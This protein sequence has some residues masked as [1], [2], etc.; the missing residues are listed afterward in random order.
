[1]SVATRW[2][3]VRVFVWHE[4]VGERKLPV[5]VRADAEMGNRRRVIPTLERPSCFVPRSNFPV[6]PDGGNS[7]ICVSLM[8][9]AAA[10]IKYSSYVCVNSG[11]MHVIDQFRTQN[12]FRFHASVRHK[13][14]SFS[15]LIPRL[16]TSL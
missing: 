3:E 6:S 1:V 4:C 10:N 15:G 2:A 13:F 16:V 8:S 7:A 14:E 5:R 9:L 11:G 12:I